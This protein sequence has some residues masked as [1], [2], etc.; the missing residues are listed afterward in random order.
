ML[1]RL[2]HLLFGLEPEGMATLAIG[3]LDPITS[4]LRFANAGHLPLLHVRGDEA[5]F[6]GEGLGPPLGA[7]PFARYEETVLELRP[8]DTAVFYT[9]GLVED[10]TRSIDAGLEQMR[11]AIINGSGSI[12]ELSDAVVRTCLGDRLVDDDVALLILR[13]VPLGDSLTLRFESDPRV[14]GS[15]RQTLRRWMHEHAV[16]ETRR[17]GRPRRLWRGLQQ[18]DRARIGRPPG[19]VPG[20]SRHRR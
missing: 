8:N 11:D 2:N 10:R 9:D 13:S 15:L 18:R 6:V 7:I 14:L 20:P 1:L 3:L 16:G 17:A 19:I 4:R 12:E 5:T